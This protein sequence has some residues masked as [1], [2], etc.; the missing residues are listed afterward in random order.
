MAKRYRTRECDCEAEMWPG[1][2]RPD[3]CEAHGN[4]FQTE[5]ELKPRER[6]ELRSVSPKRQ[7][8]EDVGTRPRRR[9]S[10]LSAGR[11]FAVANVQRAKV[12]VLVCVGCGLGVEPD[13]ASN[14]TIDP[15]HLWPR[16]LGG[17]EDE[18]CVVP[19]CRHLYVPQK[20]CHYAYDNGE[21]NLHGK[22]V[23]R[24]YWKEMAHVIGGHEVSPL[25]LANRLTG[26]EHV[27]KAEL[28]AAQA[29]IVELEAGI[30]A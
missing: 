22:L 26:E 2:K 27:G 28:E 30:A 17:C 11:G 1:Q 12:K 24:G 9:G 14:W 23:D 7:A 18:L 20:G 19:L 13:T 8:E 29:R 16:G 6:S 10:T 3:C 15:A 21:L 25:T 4:R 5:A